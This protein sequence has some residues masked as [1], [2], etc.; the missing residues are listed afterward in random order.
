MKEQQIKRWKG[1]LVGIL[2]SGITTLSV[3][4]QSADGP[5]GMYKLKEIVQQDGKHVE[6]DFLQYKYCLDNYTFT[7]GFKA[8]QWGSHTYNIG[9]SNPDGKPLAY[10][11]ELSKTENK[12]IQTWATSDSTFTV[13]WFNDRS[14]FNPRLFPFQTNIDESYELMQDSADIIRR[15]MDLLQMKLGDKVHRLHGVWKLRGHQKWNAAYSQYWIEKERVERYAIFGH[16]LAVMVVPNARFPQGEM[17]CIAMPCH[18][19][20]DKVIECDGNNMILNWFDDETVSV[21]AIDNNGYPRVTVWDRCGLPQNI[22]QVFGIDVPQMSKDISRFMIEGFEEKYGQKSN[23]IRWSFETFDY[24]VNVMERN[25]AIF[26]MLMRNGFADEYKSMKDTLLS[27]LMAEEIEVNEAVS[28]Y[29]FWFY[30]NFDRHTFCDSQYF[31]KLVSE[32]HPDYS[33][34]MSKYAPEP[35]GCKVDDKTYLLRLPSCMGE[36][37]T[38]EWLN[39]KA[40]EFKSSG[41]ENLILDLR[42]NG[43]GGDRYSLLFTYFMGSEGAIRENR[44][45]YLC[46][47]ENNNCLRKVGWR[48][49]VLAR[50]DSVEDGTYIDWWYMEE[51]TER[52][53]PLVRKGAIII[54]NCTAS[55]GESPVAFV[56]NH[57]KCRAKV[58]GKERTMGCEQTGNV[59]RVKLPNIDIT[60]TY[61]MTVHDTFEPTCKERNPGHKPDVIIPLPYP[62]QLTDNIDSWVLWVAKKLK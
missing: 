28:R 15:T 56:R 34:L 33:K 37:P 36:V 26:P 57:S 32:I 9:I 48:N 61:P 13:R 45:Y 8:P 16:D 42:G 55:A 18:F 41:C 39:K 21:S 27:R 60:L 31:R 24:A 35:V 10:T 14:D 30:K 2:L 49:D 22:Q 40:D 52:Y 7:I 38:W 5:K 23:T 54:D 47:T 29:V 51:G 6:A 58:Y 11:G 3:S 44:S 46:N 50:A 43:G 53:E 17:R 12:G 62:E 20:S 4:A 1:A 59:N 25:N 19:L